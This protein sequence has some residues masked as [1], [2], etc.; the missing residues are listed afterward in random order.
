[1]KFDFIVGNPPYQE[2]SEGV[3]SESNGQKPRT[4][5]FHYFQM[6][7]DKIATKQ[8]CLIYPGVRWIHQSGKGLKQFGLEQINDFKLSKII[9]YPK[10]KEVFPTTDIPDGVTI[11][12][13]DNAKTE[14]GFEYVYIENGI[15][16]ELYVDNPGDNLLPINPDDIVICEKIEQFVKKYNLK[17][18]NCSILPRS[19]FGIESDFIEKFNGEIKELNSSSQLKTNEI[20]VLT[21]DKAGAAG[22]SKWFIVDREVIKSNQHYIDEYQVVV[23]S[24]HA[25]GQHG[26]DNQLEI[27]DNKS[28]FGRA[29]VALKSFKTKNEAQ[30][31]FLYVSSKIIKYSFLMTAEALSSVAK[32][33]PDIMD[34]TENNQ[35][36]DFSEDIDHQLA[37]I[38]GFTKNELDYIDSKVKM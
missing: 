28:A 23:S 30:N 11:V 3:Q 37:Q 4:N 13:K 34:Y 17:Y 20:K 36:I 35:I 27:I 12:I 19:L 1:M 18:L 33:V 21:N 31:F 10:T 29:R 2:E 14:P 22:R 32:R 15:Q 5:I 6:E 8:T 26:R 25:G 16:K 9:M 7:A 38:I 24:A